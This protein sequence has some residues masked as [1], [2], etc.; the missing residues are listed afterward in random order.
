MLFFV[1]FL[2]QAISEE[3]PYLNEVTFESQVINMQKNE[4]WVVLFYEPNQIIQHGNILMKFNTA[5]LRSMDMRFGIVNATKHTSL[6][7]RLNIQQLPV[8][9]MFSP[10]RNITYEGKNE[11]RNIIK[12]AATLI[13]N[14]V[15]KIGV[16]WKDST[17]K[18]SI[19][20]FNRTKKIPSVWKAVASHYYGKN[21]RVGFSN[22]ENVFF[23]FLISKT[24]AILFSNGTQS[25][26]YRGRLIYS[27]IIQSVDRFFFKVFSTQIN[28]DVSQ[29]IVGYANPRHFNDICVGS[30]NICVLIK[31]TKPTQEIDSIKKIYSKSRINWILGDSQFPFESMNKRH[32]AWIYNPRK[33]AFIS[34]DVSNLQTTL[35]YVLNGEGKWVSRNDFQEL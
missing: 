18:P 12:K 25:I 10:T 33:D 26:P 11:P 27:E 4:V 6:I 30:K 16:S 14:F 31:A 32:G 3:I 2:R 23:P 5:A 22:D 24:P 28:E 8:I 13:P 17:G 29:T 20:L 21:I 19:M 9:K 34:T 15:Q 35:E 1:V 7:E